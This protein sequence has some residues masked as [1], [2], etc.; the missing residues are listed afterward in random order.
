ME[1]TRSDGYRISDAPGDLDRDVIHAWLSRTYW[2]HDLP[3]DVLDRAIEGSL[4]FGILD[5][6]GR[7]AGFCRVVSDMATFAWV[8]D[9]FVAEE[10]RGHGLATWM[11]EV[12]AAHPRLQGLRRWL[13]ATRDAHELYRK[14]GYAPLTAEQSDRMM[15]RPSQASYG[16]GAIDPAPADDPREPA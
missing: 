1:W 12:V 16:P 7:Q 14:T 9:V 10:Q 15:T 4:C 6:A 8:C 11:M 13:L 5:P 3:R 2:T